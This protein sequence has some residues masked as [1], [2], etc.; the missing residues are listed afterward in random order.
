MRVK[1]EKTYNSNILSDQMYL[2]GT[3]Y[4]DAAKAFQRVEDA[5]VSIPADL[6]IMDVMT[7]LDGEGD[8]RQALILDGNDKLVL[9]DENVCLQDA[10][11]VNIKGAV[12]E[13]L[14][15]DTLYFCLGGCSKTPLRMDD[16]DL[17]AVSNTS[18]RSIVGV[19]KMEHR[20]KGYFRD[21]GI[22]ARCQAMPGEK[23]VYLLC[24]EDG[25]VKKLFSVFSQEN[26]LSFLKF[27]ELVD[28]VRRH[29]WG[30]RIV[31]WS[32]EQEKRNVEF[33]CGS[34]E[35]FSVTWSDTGFTS[36]AFEMNGKVV[37][38][39]KKDALEQLIAGVCQQERPSADRPLYTYAWRSARPVLRNTNKI[40][41]ASHHFK[42]IWDRS[43]QKASNTGYT[44]HAKT[45]ENPVQKAAAV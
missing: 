23:N 39:K 6:S 36:F 13:G 9:R 22:A 12:P 31:R 43:A 44:R 14:S 3:G 42:I 40:S 32:I 8:I 11:Y 2:Y 20:Q 18:M 33:E 38:A 35:K 16:P 19:L 27:E 15:D 10:M 26:S 21:A 4:V 30:T 24:R 34:G 5:T 37:K 1:R 17:I 28:M 25:G 29:T 41:Y 45:E 7:V